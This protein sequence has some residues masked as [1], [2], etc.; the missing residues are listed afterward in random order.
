VTAAAAVPEHAASFPTPD[1]D[2]VSVVVP[3]LNEERAISSCLDSVL[4][5]THRNLEVLVLDGG[6][7]D[8]TRDIVED[9][10]RVDPRVRLVD[11]PR[12]T[13][14]AA[15]NEA[16]AA[17]RSD[18]LVRIDAHATV[19]P[20]YVERTLTH[21]RS[22][23]WGGVGGRKDGVGFTDEGRAIAAVM[24]SPFGV[25]NSTYHHGTEQCSVDHIPFGAYPRSVI[26]AV[27]GWDE[28]VPVNQDFE[29]DYRV[30]QAGHELLFDPE[31]HIAWE[32]RQSVRSF[33][34]QYR[35]Y[36][37]GKAQVARM[38]PESV[39]VRHLAAPILVAMLATALALLPFRPRWALALVA[40]Y[41]GV[42]AL[43]TA[44]V[45]PKVSGRA[46]RRAVPRAFLA[47]HVG[48]GL[49]FWEGVAGAVAHRQDE[50]V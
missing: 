45:V 1:P 21:L 29:F 39:A 33:W 5:Q 4:A 9:Y 26:E 48:W 2:L 7:T 27:G 23:R 24:A 34:R 38:H 28:N 49:G 41:A 37:R 6:S 3:A 42:V 11:N 32:C 44:T 25:G 31:L 36:G 8:R 22:G 43:G 40:P 15:L 47:M 13:P 12:R 10:R 50:A 14:P 46:A 16:T 19:P 18:W 35:R 30:R 17:M 20:D